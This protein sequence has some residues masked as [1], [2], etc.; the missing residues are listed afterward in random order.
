MLIWTGVRR[1]TGLDDTSLVQLELSPTGCFTS[2][3]KFLRI[4]FGNVVVFLGYSFICK[5]LCL[6][7]LEILGPI[8]GHGGSYPNFVFPQIPKIRFNKF[9]ANKLVSGEI[10]FNNNRKDQFTSCIMLNSS[11]ILPFPFWDLLI[12]IPILL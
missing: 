10:L 4:I 11:K 7:A 6:L 5:N 8:S 9:E 1:R 3:R 12:H 2:T